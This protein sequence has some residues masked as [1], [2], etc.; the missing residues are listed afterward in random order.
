MNCHAKIHTPNQSDESCHP[1]FTNS[2]NDNMLN[3]VGA[4]TL[5]LCTLTLEMPHNIYNILEGVPRY[6]ETQL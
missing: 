3:H 5:P 1:I 6:R 2:P 4:I